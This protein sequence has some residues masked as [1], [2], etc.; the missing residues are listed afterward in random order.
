MGLEKV[1]QEILEKAQKE[2]A[3][4]IDDAKAEAK[5][6]MTSAEKQAQEHERLIND[7]VDNS[8]AL[9]KKRELASA[10][11]QVQK[12]LLAAKNELIEGAFSDAR[13]RLKLLGEKKRE[14]HVKSLLDTAGKE[15]DLAVVLCSSSD[16]EFFERF[17]YGRL[18]IVKDDTMLGGIIAESP[19]RKLR[20]DYSYEALLER[21]RGKV[22]SD[23]ARLLFGK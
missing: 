18:K 21:V 6:V 14:T 11:L 15:I 1:K 2:A 22:L 8:I 7:D 16:A 10:E 20:V 4:I 17:S 5:A 3:K 13:K 23:V 12:Q 9:A 19:D